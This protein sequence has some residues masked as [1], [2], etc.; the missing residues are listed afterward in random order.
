MQITSHHTS[1]NCFCTTSSFSAFILIQILSNL[2]LDRRSPKNTNTAQR[3]LLVSDR[4]LPQ[5]TFY[6]WSISVLNTGSPHSAFHDTVILL[7][8]F[9]ASLSIL[10]ISQTDLS[11][12]RRQIAS[13]VSSHLLFLHIP[14]L[15]FSITT[16]LIKYYPGSSP[17]PSK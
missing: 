13:P 2:C 16:L 4:N 6:L 5:A 7:C 3:R 1:L 17:K 8:E 14:N 12:A 10:S 15:L 11:K 9:A